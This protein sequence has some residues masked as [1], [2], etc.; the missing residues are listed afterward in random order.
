MG[1]AF[2][3]GKMLKHLKEKPQYKIPYRYLNFFVQK[4]SAAD[5]KEA[6]QLQG[7]LCNLMMKTQMI[8]IIF[9]PVP[10][11]PPQI[12]RGLTRD[13]NRA[14]ALGGR[15]LTARTMARP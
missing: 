12:P 5:A 9:V 4:D 13:R 2:A 8:I 6:P 3:E 10:L 14:S 7:F 1:L 11:C 15:R